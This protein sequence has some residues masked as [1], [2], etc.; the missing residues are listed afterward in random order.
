[1]KEAFRRGLCPWASHALYTQP[2]V[3]DDTI[4]AERKLGIEAGFAWG[5][6]AP[7][8]IFGVDLGWS[9]GMSAGLEVAQKRNATIRTWTLGKPW[10]DAVPSDA[11]MDF[12]VQR[13]YCKDG[14]HL[15]Y[16]MPVKSTLDHWSSKTKM[17]RCDKWHCPCCFGH[18]TLR[19]NDIKKLYPR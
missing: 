10:S 19:E 7:L 11:E 18:V 16:E 13:A 5:A 2:G 17:T 14:N 6:K 1:M 9:R 3:L 15:P 12:R 8:V 4:P